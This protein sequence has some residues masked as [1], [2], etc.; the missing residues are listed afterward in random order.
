MTSRWLILRT[1]TQKSASIFWLTEDY[2]WENEYKWDTHNGHTTLS[3]NTI[4]SFFTLVYL[5]SF[6]EQ[7][8]HQQ[9]TR[10]NCRFSFYCRSYKRCWQLVDT[11]SIRLHFYSNEKWMEVLTAHLTHW[12]GQKPI[13][14]KIVAFSSLLFLWVLVD[15]WGQCNSCL[16]DTL[17]NS[18][19]WTSTM[20]HTKDPR[21]EHI[22][23]PENAQNIFIKRVNFDGRLDP[24]HWKTLP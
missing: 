8:H 18:K 9:R 12:R 10:T 3:F 4:H 20:K 13:D 21:L 15:L 7:N 24:I 17:A 11:Q 23:C 19:K 1:V 22:K 6:A 16:L 2:I 5:L 14:L